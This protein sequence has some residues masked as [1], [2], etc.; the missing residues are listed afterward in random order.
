MVT[1]KLCYLS[2]NNEQTSLQEKRSGNTVEPVLMNIYQGNTYRKDFSLSHL[3]DETR[4]HVEAR[5]GPTVLH[6]RFVFANHKTGGTQHYRDKKFI[7]NFI[8]LSFSSLLSD[9]RS[10]KFFQLSHSFYILQFCVTKISYQYSIK[11]AIIKLKRILK[12]RQ[13]HVSIKHV[14]LIRLVLC[15][16]FP[17]V[18]WIVFDG[19]FT[20][21]GFFFF[22]LFFFSELLKLLALFRHYAEIAFH[23]KGIFEIMQLAQLNQET[24][25]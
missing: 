14:F 5:E 3:N 24:V 8:S 17:V 18:I 25:S 6:T 12:T 2:K 4:V 7:L 1:E 13:E 16:F 10:K 22:F 19:F 20:F 21:S 23:K 15:S 9:Y 11:K